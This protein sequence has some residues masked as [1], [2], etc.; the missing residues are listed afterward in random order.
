MNGRNKKYIFLGFIAVIVIL[1]LIFFLQNNIGN[2]TKT[3]SSEQITITKKEGLMQNEVILTVDAGKDVL[4]YSF[5]NGVTWK[6][7]NTY[8][9]SENKDIKILLK[10]KNGK[11]IGE[12]EYSVVVVNN[13]G[14]TITLNNFPET[15]YVGDT[16]D[17]SKYATAVDYQGNSLTVTHDPN[18]IDTSKPSNVKIIYSTIDKDGIPASVSVELNIIEKANNNDSNNNNNNDN[19]NTTKKKQTYY[20]YRTKS[21]TEYDC[22]Y[23]QCDYID[24]N[25]PV[26]P[27]HTFSKNSKCCTGEGCTNKNERIDICELCIPQP[28]IICMMCHE[29]FVS[30][31]KVENNVCYD[32]K[33]LTLPNG[34]DNSDIYS[35]YPKPKTECESDEIKI[36]SY[37]HKIDS[38]ATTT[39]PNEYTLKDGKCYKQVKKTCANKCTSE[40]WSSWSKWQ[41]TKVIA[42]ENTQVRTM[43][44]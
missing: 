13:S 34:N 12:K 4:Y 30:R 20:S 31:Y 15:I 35:Y 22:N 14:P 11:I 43:E 21:I 26:N 24:Y 37:C 27:T 18:T 29:E 6:T 5:D 23:Y 8:T 42:N 1:T 9:V 33:P 32:Q 44:K 16:I 3:L 41:T 40:K 28:G 7:E 39:C 25:N 10:D 36:G 17:L 19:N 2:K 38:T